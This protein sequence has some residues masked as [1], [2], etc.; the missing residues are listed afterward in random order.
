MTCF[1]WQQ[2]K[3]KAM[4][5]MGE[6]IVEKCNCILCVLVKVKGHYLSGDTNMLVIT[7]YLVGYYLPPLNMNTYLEAD[8]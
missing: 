1:A 2:K 4:L 8:H 7:S 3:N 5:H 6:R